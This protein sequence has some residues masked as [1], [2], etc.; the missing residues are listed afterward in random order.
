MT[1]NIISFDLEHWHSAT[2][3][4]DSVNDPESYLEHSVSIVLDILASHDTRATFFTV[5]QVANEYPDLISQIFED[6]HEIGTHGHTHTPLF[7]LTPDDFR[8]ELSDSVDA[9]R[10]CTGTEPIGFRAPNFSITC[11]TKWAPAI[12]AE[13]DFQYDSSVF[14][15]KTPMYGVH[16]APVAPYHM[17]PEYPFDPQTDRGSG[18]LVEYPLA[19]FDASIRLPVAGGFY[20]RVL[21]QIL[22]ERGI[23]SLNRRGVPATL[24]FHP[25]EFNTAIEPPQMAWY[26]RFISFYG[27]SK[28]PNILRNLLEKFEFSSH[29]CVLET[30]EWGENPK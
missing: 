3:V 30:N 16:D 5:G 24:Y 12:L 17:N 11:E 4:Q 26:Q 9:I 29:D 18:Q 27:R 8:R 20:A 21:P 6:G 1:T 25:W 28:L 13:H 7:D 22:F 15:V 2:L 14:P 19:V 23:R 10:R